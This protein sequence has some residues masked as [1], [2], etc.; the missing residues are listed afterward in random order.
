MMMTC[1]LC[2]GD[3]GSTTHGHS[4][5]RS[6]CGGCNGAG[7]IDARWGWQ[8]EH[9]GDLLDHL[10]TT[11]EGHGGDAIRLVISI[12]GHLDDDTAADALRAAIAERIE[13]DEIGLP[14]QHKRAPID[15]ETALDLV[16]ELFDSDVWE[17]DALDDIA[18]I[19]ARTGRRTE[20]N[21]D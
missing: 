20:P 16:A 14:P 15:D 21:K 3:G 11:V 19:V 4:V 7:R 1:Q 9:I 2:G 8:G 10:A 17:A 6:P 5:H 18:A 12:L 13:H